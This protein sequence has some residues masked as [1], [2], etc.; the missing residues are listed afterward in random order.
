VRHVA[1]AI[2]AAGLVLASSFATLMLASGQASWPGVQ[3]PA[4]ALP[5]V[6]SRRSQDRRRQRSVALLPS[7]AQELMRQREDTFLRN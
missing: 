3:R 1:P 6:S 7:L 4:P 5:A 2:G